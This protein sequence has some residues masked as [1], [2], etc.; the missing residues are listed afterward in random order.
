MGDVYELSGHRDWFDDVRGDG[1][2][3]QV[4]WHPEHG[5][6]VLSL[7]HGATCTATFQLPI[8]D[9]PR[10]ITLLANSLGDAAAGNPVQSA[11]AADVG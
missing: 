2:R 7:W 6:A 10:I 3:L 1:R 9:A 8:G 11:G 5:L 4:T